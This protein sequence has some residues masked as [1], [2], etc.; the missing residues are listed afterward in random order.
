MHLEIKPEELAKIVS[1]FRAYYG[2]SQDEFSK[3]CDC[4]RTTI[5]SLE[6]T[7]WLTRQKTVDKI[8]NVLDGM[9][10]K[11]FSNENGAMFIFSKRSG[12][13]IRQH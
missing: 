12:N 6:K 5:L 11:F 13:A 9:G 1:V 3:V 8:V 10:V 7:P 2:Y 4:H